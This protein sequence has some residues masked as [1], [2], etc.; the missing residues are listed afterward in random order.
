MQPIHVKRYLTP[1]DWSGYIE[2]EDRAWIV[3][4]HSN[5]EASFWRRVEVSVDDNETPVTTSGYIDVEIPR[6]VA[7]TGDD[8]TKFAG[9]VLPVPAPVVHPGPIDYVTSFV[10]EQEA[11]KGT[12]DYP[13]SLNIK[14]H[15]VARLNC[16]SIAC[17]GE[18]E[19]DAVRNLMNYVA[20]LCTAGCMDHT[21]LPVPG[22]SPRRRAAV[23]G[24]P[25]PQP[26]QPTPG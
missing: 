4:V 13:D 16:R 22:V 10:P 12:P 2:P 18:T 23:W 9:P 8:D 17:I 3:F 19:H 11:R 7:R 26:D 6:G 15:W 21:G 1:N 5:G 20:Q 25:E 14:E 24:P